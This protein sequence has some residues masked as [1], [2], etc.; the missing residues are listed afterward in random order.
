MAESMERFRALMAM[1]EGDEVRVHVR[2]LGLEDLPSHDVTIRVAYSSVNYKDGLASR[3]DG[4][5]VRAYPIVPGIDL[6]G[7]VVASET[8]A[9][10][11]GTQV[12]ATGY[13][14]GV[15]QFGGYAEYA[16]VPAEWL[17]PLPKGLTL[18]DAMVLGTAGFTAALAVYKLE[19]NGLRGAEGPVLVTGASGGV[20]SVATAILAKRGYR[21]VASTGKSQAQDVLLGLGATEVIDRAEVVEESSKPLERQRWSGAVDVVGGRTLASILRTLKYGGSVAA[22][23]LTGGPTFDA[24]VFPFIL[25][26]VN[27]LGI[28]SVYAPWEVRL[29]LWKWLGGDWNVS[30]ALADVT[31]VVGMEDLPRVFTSILQGEI[32]GRVVVQIQR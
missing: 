16:R 22:C 23:G 8:N 4:R 13:E 9:F 17:I 31:T 5:V 24:A 30:G 21:V 27:L 11:P 12:L 15:S 3:K 18:R 14:L 2:D 19:Q 7:T 29:K 26:G 28:D 25:R 10:R 20:G 1:L 32:L 6:A